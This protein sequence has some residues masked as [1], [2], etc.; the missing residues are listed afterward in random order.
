MRRPVILLALILLVLLAALAATSLLVRPPPLRAHSSTGQF[1]AVRAKERLAY[2]LGDQRPHPA[3]TE[4]SD[5]VRARLVAQ[6]QQLGLN[7]IVRDQFACNELY[8]QRGV[9]CA[10]VRNIIVILGP[11]GGKAVLLNA[12]YD[13]TPVGPGAADDGIGVATLLDIAEILKD[14]PL[15]RPVILLFNE[16]EELG[17]VGAR[18]FLA[19]PLNRNVD[20]LINLEAR[21]VRGPV[22][23]FETSRP[24]G[25]PMDAFAGAVKNPVA[26]SLS[27]DVYRL[28]P[29]YTD[30]NSFAERGWLT[31]NLAPIGNETRYHSPGDDIA[32]LDPAT[33]QHMGDQ[34]LALTKALASAAPAATSGDRIFMDIAG[35]A[36]ITLPLLAAAVLLVG[37]LIAFAVLSLQRG[38]L[39]RAT[40]AI[41]GT[42]IGATILSWLLLALVGA[43]RHGMFWRAHPIWTHLT[44][45]AATILAA[46][47]LL[48]AI[49]GGLDRTRL[50][51][52]FWFIFLIIGGAIGLIAPGGIIFFIFPPLLIVGA[53]LAA[54]WWQ[55]AERV[56]SAVAI[57]VLYITWG[58]M[59]G[60]LE[61]LLNGGPIW[62]FAPLGSLLIIPV[63]I[64]AM[65]AIRAAGPRGAVL[66]P[67]AL[68]LIAVAAS[69][70]APAYSAD[71]QQRFVIQHATDVS[72]GKSWWSVLNDG[73]PLP[74][75]FAGSW[76]RGELPFSDRPRWLAPAPA[77]G[78][79]HA[80]DVV[81][82]SQAQNGNQRELM[83]RLV[84]NGNEHVD[85][86]A[87]PDA[88]ILAAGTDG[89]IRPID[90]NEEG[91]YDIS[92]F[93]RSCDGAIVQL[94]I[95][96]LQ[97][98]A[99]TALGGRGGLAPS[100]AP[101]LAARPRFARP[102]YNR[103]ESIAF[104][105]RR[106]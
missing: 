23:M 97:P 98:V 13:S 59:L 103:D 52:A 54:R 60:L 34:T 104:R 63:L 87:P 28:L 10:R 38:G 47:T 3:D 105:T 71:R 11:P 76:K 78:A 56:G 39:F 37:L 43:M 16:G 19:D 26:N 21:G 84:A 79:S 80:P 88:K 29:N 96:R 77:D 46:V 74:N 51:A 102:Q 18:A 68:T 48:N 22:N 100:A 81:L 9:S 62:I 73:A 36:L 89:F 32:A 58:A 6:L 53:M 66:V 91:K 27:T 95:G 45:Y 64:E 7:P 94:T 31:L 83:L 101:L 69:V 75:G 30:V 41:A 12:H 1:D 55:P 15:K 72:H 86:I 82:L 5:V 14:R 50:R 17:L 42:M 49:G 4:G 92:C 2:I 85:L 90:Q 67:G 106:L 8:K 70:A 35:R 65:P 57:L 44:V 93:G 40:L 33:L 99:F 24:N 61:E 20:S 25:G